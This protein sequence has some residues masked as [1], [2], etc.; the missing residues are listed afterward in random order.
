MACQ[1]EVRNT[2][3]NH[4]ELQLWLFFYFFFS[5]LI[6]G[7]LF[8]KTQWNDCRG[9]YCLQYFEMYQKKNGKMT[10]K[11]KENRF[12]IKTRIFNFMYLR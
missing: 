1:S 5:F 3:S 9:F 7:V 12:T 8:S 4:L 6:S 2:Y 11:N 10:D